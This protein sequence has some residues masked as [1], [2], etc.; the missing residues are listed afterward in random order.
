M[1]TTEFLSNL[2]PNNKIKFALGNGTPL[3][4]ALCAKVGWDIFDCTLPTRDAR[5]KRLYVFNW[6]PKTAEDLEN[7]KIHGYFYAGREEYRR[8]ERPVS[9]FCDCYTCKNYSRAYLNHLFEIGDALA[10]RLA[11]IHNLRAY[12]KVIEILRAH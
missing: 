4:I 8:D 9:E 3:E 5:N 7:P 1:D 10:E 2:I 11:T 6:E 12:S